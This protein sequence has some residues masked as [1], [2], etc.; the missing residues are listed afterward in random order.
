VPT[1][2]DRYMHQRGS[3]GLG[4]VRCQGPLHRAG[5]T[6]AKLCYD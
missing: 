5:E 3:G 2:E 6:R 4:Q 1:G